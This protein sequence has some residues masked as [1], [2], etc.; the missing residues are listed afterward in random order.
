[1][2]RG[3]CSAAQFRASQDGRGIRG[4][5]AVFNHPSDDLGGFSERVMPGAFTRCLRSS[6]DVRCLFN[7]NASQ[8]LGRTASGT[9]RLREDDLGLFFDCDLPDTQLG[10]DVQEM[11]KRGDISQCSFGFIVQGQRWPNDT[12]R[13]LT[14]VDMLDVSPVTFPAYPQTSVSARQAAHWPDGVPP[15]VRSRTSTSRSRISVPAIPAIT[16]PKPEPPIQHFESRQEQLAI[17]DR[18]ASRLGFNLKEKRFF[19]RTTEKTRSA[20]QRFAFGG[21]AAVRDLTTSTGGAFVPEGFQDEV[22][23]TMKQVDELTNPEVV[24]HLRTDNGAPLLLFGGDDVENVATIVGEGNTS[25]EVDPTALQQTLLPTVPTWDSGVVACSL[26]FLQD[27]AVDISV[28]LAKALGIR[29]ARG[30]GQ[31]LVSTLESSA[32][33]GATSTST[34]Q[35]AYDDLLNLRSSVDEAY[36]RSAK[37]FWLMSD[38]TLANIDALVDSVGQP[39]IKPVFQNGRRIIL[40]YPV[41]FSPSLPSIAANAKA[42]YFGDFSRFIFR[43]VNGIEKGS[44]DTKSGQLVRLWETPGFVENLVVGFKCFMRAQ[45]ALMDVF[46]DGSPAVSNSPVKYLQMA[47]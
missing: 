14:D 36:R 1:M 20:I 26:Q 19:M 13:E 30:I 17:V 25:S 24:T 33:E 8:L 41:A 22:Y 29:L 16:V 44:G 6:P 11:V 27:S 4:Y 32:I 39:I 9:L 45:G 12:T 35:I 40:G 43:T 37:C 3:I 15:E 7:H 31:S 10:R 34:S 23:D 21:H 42:A 5:A 18:L 38:A 2:E 47:A 46:D 28:W